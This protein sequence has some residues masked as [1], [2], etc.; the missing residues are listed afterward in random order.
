[1]C[2]DE[3][4]EKEEDKEERIKTAR[5]LLSDKAT[6]ISRSRYTCP[7]CCRQGRSSAEQNKAGDVSPDPTG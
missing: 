7:H 4:V 1:M 3:N 5:R 6:I 2:E